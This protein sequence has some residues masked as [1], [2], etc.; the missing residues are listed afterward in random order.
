MKVLG[1]T[2]WF[3]VPG[4]NHGRKSETSIHHYRPGWYK[5]CTDGYELVHSCSDLNPFN[6][7]LESGC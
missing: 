7:Y 4:W 1:C 3:A 2:M 5:G 6:R